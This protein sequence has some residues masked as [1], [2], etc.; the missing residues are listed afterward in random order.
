M[1]TI[2]PTVVETAMTALAKAE[3]V[4]ATTIT[5]ITVTTYV[6]ASKGILP[7]EGLSFI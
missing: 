6:T 1:I 3:M 4:G 5:T 7:Q 2:D